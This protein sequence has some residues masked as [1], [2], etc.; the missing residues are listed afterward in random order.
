MTPPGFVTT[1]KR[2]VVSRDGRSRH[3]GYY[4]ITGAGS[5]AVDEFARASAGVQGRLRFAVQ[6]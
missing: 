3:V 6:T 5:S 2:S 1:R 4:K